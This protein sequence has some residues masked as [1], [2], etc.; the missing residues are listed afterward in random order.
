VYRVRLGE[1]RVW[2]LGVRADVATLPAVATCL[3]LLTIDQSLGVIPSERP[4]VPGVG[5][6]LP[7]GSVRGALGLLTTRAQWEVRRVAHGLVRHEQGYVWKLVS[8]LRDG[9]ASGGVSP[10]PFGHP[11]LN[12][13]LEQFLAPEPPLSSLLRRSERV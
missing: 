13:R 4:S 9:R 10:V 6:L 1:A 2:V 7:D 11:L 3:G 8:T 5:L 12:P